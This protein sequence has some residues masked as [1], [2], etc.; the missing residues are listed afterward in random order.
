[1]S[2]YVFRKTTPDVV[3]D[4]CHKHASG[5]LYGWSSRQAV[6]TIAHTWMKTIDR[7][8]PAE[9]STS[10]PPREVLDLFEQHGAALYRFCRFTLGGEADAEDAV[11]ETFLKLLQHLGRQGERSNL[12]AW[13]F[14]VAA[15]A[16]RDR[17]R[18]RV[19]WLPWRADLDRR[20]VDPSDATPGRHDAETA[21]RRLSA[22]DRLLLSLRAQGLSY[23]E[24]AA[25]A[26]LQ[27]QSVGRLLA[28]AVDR[29]K[30]ALEAR[31]SE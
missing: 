15:N 20:A 28:R 6:T 12:R 11:Q 5:P 17:L 8:G 24:I 29:W 2:F 13:L 26:G 21:M 7:P 16:C 27:P 10:D 3:L 18:W 14:T 1:V 30:R 19:R 23:R 22:R 4:P 9:V 31:R 25:A